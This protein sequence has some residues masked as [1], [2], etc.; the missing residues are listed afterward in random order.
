M[1]RINLKSKRLKIH[2][3]RD[4]DLGI[5]IPK[6]FLGFRGSLLI[7]RL[8]YEKFLSTE[9]AIVVNNTIFNPLNFSLSSM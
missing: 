4:E 8:N 1:F 6:Y 9:K 7:I 3:S 2:N 5:E